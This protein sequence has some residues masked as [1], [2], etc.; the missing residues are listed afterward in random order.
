MPL[1]SAPSP[2]DFSIERAMNGPDPGD[3]W[4]KILSND[5]LPPEVL[6][7]DAW[8]YPE[9]LESNL[10]ESEMGTVCIGAECWICVDL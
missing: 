1:Q 7:G 3:D 2:R 4:M 8:M 6:G 9:E 5:D 10:V